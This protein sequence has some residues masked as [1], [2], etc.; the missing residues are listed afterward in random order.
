VLGAAEALAHWW[1]RNPAMS[2]QEAAELLVATIEPGL[3]GLRPPGKSAKQTSKGK[4]T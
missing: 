4:R 2:A 1:L 3:L